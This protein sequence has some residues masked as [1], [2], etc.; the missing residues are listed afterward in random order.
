MGSTIR[1]QVELYYL[2]KYPGLDQ[3]TA[4]SRAIQEVDP[5][6]DNAFTPEEAE[7]LF[8]KEDMNV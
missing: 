6:L 8:E 2:K 3:A 5:N 4:L 1:E 7:K